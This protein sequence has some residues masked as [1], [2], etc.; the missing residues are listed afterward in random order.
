MINR[1][2]L[3]VSDLHRWDLTIRRKRRRSRVRYNPRHAQC[4]PCCRYPSTR[5]GRSRT[6]GAGARLWKCPAVPDI[7]RHAKT[8]VHPSRCQR[9]PSL[10]S[11]GRCRRQSH[12][13]WSLWIRTVLFPPRNTLHLERLG[14]KSKPSR[15]SGSRAVLSWKI[16]GWACWW[17]FTSNLGIWRRSTR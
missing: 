10:A 8:T 14:D 9:S 13:H 15:V 12:V 2:C 11:L 7:C 6:H 16:H 3:W 17:Y 4:R 1:L 5:L